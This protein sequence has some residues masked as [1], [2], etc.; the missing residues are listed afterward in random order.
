MQAGKSPA[1]YLDILRQ[2]SAWGTC[3][4]QA[5]IN[6]YL[7][8]LVTWL[9][10]YLLRARHLSLNQMARQAALLFLMAA[11]SSAVAGRLGDRWIQAGAS[12]TAVRK[13]LM[14]FGHLGIGAVLILIVKTTG[15][16]FIGMLALTGVFLGICVCNSWAFPQTLAG[17]RMVGRWVGMQNFIG[18]LG[19]AVAPTLTGFLLG[20]TGSFYWPFFI[21][22]IVAWIGAVAWYFVVGALDEVDWEKYS[23][24]IPSIPAASASGISQP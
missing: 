9:P 10:F 8:F 22:A 2:R 7:Y 21:T 24:A 3:I 19:G 6:Y 13:G 12:L 16:V 23:R 14:A 1:G 5:A 18:N 20:R 17:P 11:L 4:G 15:P